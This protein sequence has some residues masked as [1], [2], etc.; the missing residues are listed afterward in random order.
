MFCVTYIH[1]WTVKWLYS[2]FLIL[3]SGDVEIN[4]G[5]RRSTDETFS[6]WHW[7]LNGLSAYNC[8]KLL[9]PKAYVAVPKVDVVSL[10]ETYLNSTVV[11][12]DENLEIRGYNLVRS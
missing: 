1:L 9:F 11:S 8:N 12:D 4:P 5:P 2:F 6:I 3:I 10:S 7:N